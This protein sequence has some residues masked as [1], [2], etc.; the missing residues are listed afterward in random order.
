MK[1]LGI[2]F[3]AVA[4]KVAGHAAGA[5]AFTQ[6]NKAK[7]MRSYDAPEK[8]AAKGLV[9]AAI[10][11]LAVPMIAKKTGLAGKGAKGAFAESVGE[12][13]GIVGLMLLG[14]AVIKPA[15]GK[16]AL[17][18]VISG[19]DGYEENPIEGLGEMYDD[20]SGYE[21]DPIEGLHDELDATAV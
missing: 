3:K 13:L 6:L 19:V 10:G 21:Q 17:F 4:A 8:Q 14:N 16:P 9:A 5:A 1:V 15:A 20:V 11:Y 2:D 7:F 18:P 12:G